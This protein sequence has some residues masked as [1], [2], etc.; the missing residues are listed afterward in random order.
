MAKSL[1]EYTTS[2]EFK[3]RLSESLKKT[4]AIRTQLGLPKAVIVDGV[5]FKE[6]PDGR[7]ERINPP[8]R[9]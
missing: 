2:S 7:R 6:Y 8:S 4:D 9:P 1:I 5:V 3:R